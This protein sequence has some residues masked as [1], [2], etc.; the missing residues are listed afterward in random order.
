MIKWLQLLKEKIKKLLFGISWTVDITQLSII[1]MRLKIM[2]FISSS[3][4]SSNYTEVDKRKKQV[5]L[6]NAK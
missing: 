1:F 6:Y 4:K 3:S 2:N 5:V